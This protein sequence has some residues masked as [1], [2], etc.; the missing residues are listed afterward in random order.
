MAAPREL[1]DGPD[2]YA[3]PA[4]YNSSVNLDLVYEE[5]VRN[6][7][8]EIAALMRALTYGEMID[9]AEGLHVDPKTIHEWS[10]GYETKHED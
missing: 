7:L 6:R 5:T 1:I 3:P 2:G 9:L 4:L 8:A 10:Q